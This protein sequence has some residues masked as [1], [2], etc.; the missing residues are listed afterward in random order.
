MATKIL[1]IGDK[2]SWGSPQGKVIGSVNKKLVAPIDI[3]T[4]H[5]AASPEHPQWLV[6][7]DSTGQVVAHKPAA[8]KRVKAK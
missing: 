7:S 4:H 2:V 1:K 8:F 5:V 6:K 3:K